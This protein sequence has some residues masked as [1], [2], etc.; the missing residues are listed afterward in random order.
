MEL[1]VNE[2]KERLLMIEEEAKLTFSEDSEFSCYIVG[3]GALILM[4]YI[5]RS[6]HDIDAISAYPDEIKEVYEH[7]DMNTDCMVFISN[8]AEGY[9]ERA[10]RILPETTMVKFYV[11]SLEDI[12]ISKLCSNGAGNRQK[13]IF[14]INSD[15]VINDLD[16][17]KLDELAKIVESQ[18]FSSIARDDFVW[19]YKDYVK[20]NKNA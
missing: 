9:Q 18:Q 19:N 4:G 7:Y 17:E 20:R 14:D 6:T 10:I 15:K 8:F 13:D 3:G 1:G 16:W 12:V 11:L 2:L 5:V